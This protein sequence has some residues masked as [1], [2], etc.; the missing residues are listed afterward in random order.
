MPFL[1]TN[2]LLV[3][4]S[5]TLRALTNSEI[6]PVSTARGAVANVSRGLDWQ[7]LV[8]LQA[9][10]HPDRQNIGFLMVIMMAHKFML[11]KLLVLTS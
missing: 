10:I 6:A 8:G 3:K 1:S 9:Q 5:L 2:I 7:R 11:W 4:M